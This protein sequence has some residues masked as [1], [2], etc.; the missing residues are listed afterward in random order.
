MHPDSREK[1]AFNV[2]GGHYQYNRMPF[3]L[4]N[5]PSTFQRMMDGVLRGLKPTQ[6]LVYL[7][8]V[9]IFGASIE[10]HAERL[11]GVFERLREAKLSLKFEKCHFAKERVKYL[12][13]VIDKRGVGPD[14][15]KIQAVMSYP[16][17]TTIREVQSF[18]GLSNY[19]RRFVD[20]YA[21]TARPLTRLLK[22]GEKFVWSTECEI[23]FETL[24]K[25]LANSPVLSHPDF[26][27][28]FILSTDASNFAVGAVLSQ[29]ID[30]AEHP[31]A[32]ASRQLNSAEVNYTVT[33]RE[34]LAI[35]WAVKYF[36]CYLYGR[37]FTICTDHAA[38]RWLF[39]LLDP[40]SRL[41]RWTLKLSEYEYEVVH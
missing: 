21:L 35:V 15:D 33:E 16:A 41:M 32:Y 18:L 5:A 26:E 37:K 12:G 14:P 30:G 8:D 36:R 28:P 27:K 4:R 20:N 31:V 3:G 6:C 11:R 10:E 1:T 17:P 22:K 9:I 19:Y 34:L 25:S 24:K 29:E 39:S 38:L 2:E 7:D 40:N 23:A 13:H